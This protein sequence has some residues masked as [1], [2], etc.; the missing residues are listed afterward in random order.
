MTTVEI[1]AIQSPSAAGDPLDPGRSAAAA[2]TGALPPMPWPKT[3]AAPTAAPAPKALWRRIMSWATTTIVLALLALSIPLAVIPALHGGTALTVLTGSMQPTLQPGD[4]AIV[5]PV[6]GFDDIELGDVV[7]F[8]PKPDD[9]TLVTHR[10]IA[11]GVDGDGN[12]ILTTQGDANDAA[13]SPIQE[14]QLRAKLAYSVPWIGNVLQYSDFSKPILVVIAAIGLIAYAV[15]AVLTSTVA[16]GRKR[17]KGGRHRTT[18][19]NPATN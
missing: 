5:Y 3:A 8:M 4:M 10:A 1:P 7:T 2:Q 18:K 14:Q 17:V 12:R 16:S 11:W 9:P 13:D 6:D 19:E 15:Y